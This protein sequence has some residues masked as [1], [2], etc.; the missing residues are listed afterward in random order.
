MPCSNNYLG[1][2]DRARRAAW[3]CSATLLDSSIHP[4]LARRF[5]GFFYHSGQRTHQ[6]VKATAAAG[7][8]F[9]HMNHLEAYKRQ[10][11]TTDDDATWNTTKEKARSKFA[12]FASSGMSTAWHKLATPPTTHFHCTC[13]EYSSPQ[14]IH[15]FEKR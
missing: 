6:R 2:R 5:D 15:G 10:T 9:L 11:T 4:R 1:E 8:G 7:H 14:A 13:T 3:S 12:A